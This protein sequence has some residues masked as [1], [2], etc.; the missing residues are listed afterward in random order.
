MSKPKGSV[1]T[2]EQDDP[3]HHYKSLVQPLLDRSTEA[4]NKKLPREQT[5]WWFP[6]ILNDYQFL[7]K[8]SDKIQFPCVFVRKH[9]AGIDWILLGESEAGIFFPKDQIDWRTHAP[10]WRG[11]VNLDFKVV[12]AREKVQ[13]QYE[14]ACAYASL[15]H[16]SYLCQPTHHPSYFLIS[17]ARPTEETPLV[18]LTTI[19]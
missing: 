9:G 19:N 17:M 14:R 1:S 12:S 8:K 7:A 18:A 4:K 10:K 2:P 3:L 15:T 5:D 13:S 16:F 6:I 11:D